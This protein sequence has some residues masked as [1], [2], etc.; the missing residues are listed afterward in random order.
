MRERIR[1]LAARRDVTVAPPPPPP[2]LYPAIEFDAPSPPADAEP[3][4]YTRLA[5]GVRQIR[6]GSGFHPGEKT[7]LI[8][9]G[10]LAPV[11]LAIVVIGWYGAAHT[12]YLFE[13][14]PYLI[15]GG[16]IGLG[17]VF[18]GS[19][20]YF[21]HWLTCLVKEHR[22]Q[23]AAI[24][25]ALGRL[26]DTLQVQGAAAGNGHG[27]ARHDGDAVLVAT[28]KGTMAHRPDCPVVAGKPN[29]HAVGS[30]QDLEPCKLCDPYRE[31]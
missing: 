14:V 16:F 1:P 19:F 28:A 3:G 2:E 31:D 24:L 26:Q 22:T 23:S 4:R 5:Q 13:Q 12:P 20:F 7:L 18:L 30:D 10:V 21:A 17:L 9:G 8:L 25:D 29:V 27:V 15:S 11:G 6:V